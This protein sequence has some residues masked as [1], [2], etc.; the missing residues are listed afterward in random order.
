M[1]I[2]V[3]RLAVVEQHA[4][5]GEVQEGSLI[6]RLRSAEN[7]V[8]GAEQ[9]GMP[10]ERVRHLEEALGIREGE[11]SQSPQDLALPAGKR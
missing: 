5:I 6:A 1:P 7:A 10:V 4:G 8:L 3:E 11:M 2:L 9:N